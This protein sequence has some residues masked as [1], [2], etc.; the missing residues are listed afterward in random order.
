M[1]HHKRLSS[2]IDNFDNRMKYAKWKQELVLMYNYE[3]LASIVKKTEEVKRQYLKK[4]QEENLSNELL[5]NTDKI[6]TDLSTFKAFSEKLQ[7]KLVELQV[8][9]DEWEMKKQVLNSELNDKR[10]TL[11]RILD[12]N[13]KMN[14][15]LLKKQGIRN[16]GDIMVALRKKAFSLKAF[17]TAR[18]HQ[19]TNPATDRK[20]TNPS[21]VSTKKE[22][23]LPLVPLGLNRLLFEECFDLLIKNIRSMNSS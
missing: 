17:P 3:P 2:Y 12:E 4:I 6:M 7:A 9:I 20:P 10:V 22:Q 8:S 13:Y 5:Y 11:K 23:C 18:S 19:P 16:K 14:T 1:E 21:S 15:E